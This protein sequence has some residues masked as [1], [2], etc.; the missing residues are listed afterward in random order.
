MVWENNQNKRRFRGYSE[1][2]EH[3]KKLPVIEQR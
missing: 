2:E 3:I 1:I